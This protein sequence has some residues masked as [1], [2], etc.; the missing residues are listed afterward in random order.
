MPASLRN[1]FNPQAK[2]IYDA[3]EERAGIVVFEFARVVEP[4]EASADLGFGL[5]QDRHIQTDERLAQV[6]VGTETA[7]TAWRSAYHG[8]RLLRLC[9]LATGPGA[10]IDGIIE[11]AGDRTIVFG[12]DEQHRIST[13]N[14]LTKTSPGCRRVC[15]HYIFIVRRHTLYPDE[16]QMQ[17]G[18]C[19]SDQ[20]FRSFAIDGILAQAANDYSNLVFPGYEMLPTILWVLFLKIMV[21]TKFRTRRGAFYFVVCGLPG[22]LPNC[23]SNSI[24][25]PTTGS[26][27]SIRNSR[28]QLR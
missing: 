18:R 6:M 28:G 23:I 26:R 20:R 12:S 3:F 7:D 9:A 8:G 1:A 17:I 4:V 22:Q 13:R 16:V 27:S 25:T 14:V 15:C 24:P 21:R 11:C 2:C 5:L 19:R 10:H